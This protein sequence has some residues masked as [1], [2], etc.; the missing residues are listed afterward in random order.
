MRTPKAALPWHGSTLLRRVVGVL[1]RSLDGPLVVVRAPGQELPDLPPSVVVVADAREGRGPLQ[2]LA[3][4][5]S[6]VAGTDVA[7]VASTDVP[8]LH[9]AFV[10]RVVGAVGPGIDIA[11]PVIGGRPHPLSAAYRPSVLTAVETLLAEDRLRLKTLLD[12]CPSTTLDEAALRE[13]PA[14]AASDPGLHSVQNVNDAEAYRRLCATPLPPVRI[15]VAQAGGV[16]RTEIAP[17]ATLGAA[18]AYVALDAEHAWDAT[19][20]GDAVSW[21]AEL[22]LVAGDVVGF[23]VT[24]RPG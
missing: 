10:R 11:V 5:L 9:P 12:L 16:A 14:L 18:A 19:V 23:R 17:V 1:G 2:G 6:A 15:E 21:D 24:H 13:D 8:L 22:P 3:A 20:N 7:F 4:G